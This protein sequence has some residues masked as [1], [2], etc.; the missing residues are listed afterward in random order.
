MRLPLMVVMLLG[1]ALEG[2][3]ANDFWRFTYMRGAERQPGKDA[4]DLGMV[5]FDSDMF[6]DIPDLRSDLRLADANGREV[7]FMVKQETRID[8]DTGRAEVASELLSLEREGNSVSLILR[9]TGDPLVPV[10]EVVLDTPDR[11]FDK[12]ASVYVSSDR[13]NWRQ[14]ASGLPFFD[15]SR[16]VDLTNRR[17]EFPASTES[18]FKVVID[19]F[20]EKAESPLRQLMTETR[21]GGDFRSGSIALEWNDGI[22]IT[23]ARLFRKIPG[24]IPVSVNYPVTISSIGS[25]DSTTVICL[26]TR[27]E[28]LNAFEL[29]CGDRNFSRKVTVSRLGDKGN[30]ESIGSGRFEDINVK[31]FKRSRTRVE[32]PESRATDYKISVFN[33]D[34]L[35]LENISVKGSGPGYYA[36]FIDTRS[37]ALTLYYGGKAPVPVYDLAAVTSHLA[38]PARVEYIPGKEQHNPLYRP[39]GWKFDGNSVFILAIV[40]LAFILGLILVRNIRH[41]KMETPEDDKDGS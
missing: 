36:G 26:K 18:Y 1:M 3:A 40:L 7:P 16:V 14:V 39:E 12:T 24:E 17:L 28:P 33:G 13:K 35:P 9:Q 37:P 5:R 6:E 31:G 11:D 32:F 2:L 23:K 20:K 10:S 41:L 22:K 38:N 30:W 15:Y 8:A 29:G 27:R 21:N 19:N 4:A 25:R 34:N